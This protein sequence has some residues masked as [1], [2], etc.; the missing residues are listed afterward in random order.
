MTQARNNVAALRSLVAS[1]ES[2]GAVADGSTDNRDA[3]LSAVGAS[4]VVHLGVGTYVINL[5]EGVTTAGLPITNITSIVGQGP[6]A[7]ILRF[8]VSD[9]AGARNLF[10]ITGRLALAGLRVE[11]VNSGTDTISFFRGAGLSG[12]HLARCQFDGGVTDDGVAAAYQAYGIYPNNTGTHEDIT[13][14]DCD[15][16]RRFTW[17]FAKANE[18]TSEQ[19]RLRFLRNRFREHYRT[20]LLFNSPKGSIEDVDV[21]GNTFEGGR[22][23]TLGDVNSFHIAPMGRG[24]RI[25]G[26]RMTGL[27][28]A[29]IHG[30]ENLVDADI[31]V[32]QIELDAGGVIGIRLLANSNGDGVTV[33][34]PRKVRVAVNTVT[35]LGTAG[36]S[37]TRGIQINSDGDTA[38]T[39]ASE[40]DICGNR[41]DGFERGVTGHGNLGDGVRVYDN[42]AV[43]CGE[44]Y[45]SSGSHAVFTRNTSQGCDVGVYGANGACFKDHVF[46]DCTV[47]ASNGGRWVHLVAPRFEFLPVS[48]GAASTTNFGTFDLAAQNRITGTANAYVTCDNASD[49]GWRTYT[50][51]WDGT[52]ATLTSKQL[53]VIGG[54]TL[55]IENVSNVLSAKLVSTS[56]RADVRMAVQFT[57]EVLVGA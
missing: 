55:T 23:V 19:R 4:R 47:A 54:F 6:T 15:D 38:T 11:L 8:V 1:A 33:V 34:G 46:I 24:V 12:L 42:A 28:Y 21:D 26:N 36:A 31:S 3:F 10:S 52:T 49:I 44:G 27:V 20:P 45:R 18:A 25:R 32:N 16:I 43:N 48:V 29:A 51:E 53:R 57:G 35:Y 9:T 37:G 13:V 30:E 17:F 7:S 39:D 40:V 56:A 2:F 14:E 41:V 22:G 50:A 5:L